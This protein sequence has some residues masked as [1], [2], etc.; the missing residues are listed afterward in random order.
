[1]VHVALL[2]RIEKLNGA[3]FVAFQKERM[4]NAEPIGCKKLHFTVVVAYLANGFKANTFINFKGK[5]TNKFSDKISEN[6][7][8]IRYSL[9]HN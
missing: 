3:V 4:P 5:T 8:R 9:L 2:E 7:H 6:W 1:M